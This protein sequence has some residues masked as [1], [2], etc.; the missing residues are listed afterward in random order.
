MK[1]VINLSNGEKRILTL[2]GMKIAVEKDGYR[3]ELNLYPADATSWFF[4]WI[5]AEINRREK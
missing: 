4:S 1:T 5:N 2:N 3:D